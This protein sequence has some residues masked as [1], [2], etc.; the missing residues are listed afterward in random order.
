MKK[1]GGRKKYRNFKY[2]KDKRSFFGKITNIFSFFLFFF[3]FFDEKNK[4]IG[5]NLLVFTKV[6]MHQKLE[7]DTYKNKFNQKFT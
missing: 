5:Q 3:V 2:L 6:I 4:K 7:F 1:S